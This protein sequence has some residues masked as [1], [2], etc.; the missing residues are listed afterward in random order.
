MIPIATGYCAS[1]ICILVFICVSRS[2]ARLGG[3]SIPGK[4]IKAAH[5]FTYVLKLVLETNISPQFLSWLFFS[6]D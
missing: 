1:F 4:S 3:K 5:V 2:S 6:L